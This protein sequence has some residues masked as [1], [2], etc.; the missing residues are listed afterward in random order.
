[1]SAEIRDFSFCR[2]SRGD[3]STILT[4]L[5]VDSQDDDEWR[6]GPCAVRHSRR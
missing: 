1:V 4:L 2:P 6:T 3:T 5:F